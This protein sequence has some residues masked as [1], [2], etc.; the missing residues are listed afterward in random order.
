MHVHR[1][2]GDRVLELQPVR[3][4]VHPAR[5]VV[6]VAVLALAD[7]GQAKMRRVDPDLSRLRPLP[8]YP[9]LGPDGALGPRRTFFP[10]GSDGMAM[11]SD[12]A[13]VLTG[14][15]VH[16][17]SADGAL[18]RTLVPAERWISNA[19]FDEAE[20]RLVVTA[21]DR[22]LVFDLSDDLAGDG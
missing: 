4:Q 21:V 6:G 13:M 1:I 11:S 17:V 15:G 10:L 16:V 7:E 14:K 12:G 3:V 8:D 19:C 2:A 18:I 9:L 22:V 20:R 5:T